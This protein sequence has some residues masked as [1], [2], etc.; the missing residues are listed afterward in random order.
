MKIGIFDSGVGGIT[1][2]QHLRAQGKNHQYFYFGDTANV[3]YGS[4]SVT[5][6]KELSRSAA[7]RIKLKNLDALVVACNTASSLALDEMKSVLSP[8]PVLGVVE[9]GVQAVLKAIEG[10]P[11]DSVSVL[12]LGTKA[13]VKSKIYSRL[14]SS[15]LPL[16]SV[17]EQACPLLVPM[18]EEGWVQHP[19]L[20]ET[21][22][23]YVRSYLQ[24]KENANHQAKIA[25][26]AC[27]HYPWIR[28]TF[29]K[30]M[31]GWKV[32]DS[33]EAIA[34]Q[35]SDLWGFNSSQEI[36]HHDSPVSWFFSDPESVPTFIEDIG[37]VEKF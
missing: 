37:S 14:L 32:I 15:H 24:D 8:L 31:P 35:L 2:L 13:T 1:V 28:T 6:I 30:A 5:Q 7:E 11:V 27:T 17:Q 4:K 22:N 29:E 36:E 10:N 9:A 20:L 18:I 21:V 25:L 16:N 23:E 19:V 3:P 26:L 34:K 33:A 12:I